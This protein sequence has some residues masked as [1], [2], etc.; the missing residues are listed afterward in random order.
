MS[1]V[2]LDCPFSAQENRKAVVMIYHFIHPFIQSIAFN[3]HSHLSLPLSIYE[4]T[5]VL[6]YR[7]FVLSRLRPKDLNM[8]T[9]DRSRPSPSSSSS[10]CSPSDSALPRSDRLSLK[11]SRMASSRGSPVTAAPVSPDTRNGENNRKSS[12]AFILTGNQECDQ[13]D[14]EQD[15]DEEETQSQEYG[16]YQ[17]EY[18]ASHS[19]YESHGYS[20]QYSRAQEHAQ[21]Y[22]HHQHQKY[23]PQRSQFRYYL[24]RPPAPAAVF[25]ATPQMVLQPSSHLEVRSEPP[26]PHFENGR[27]AET[28]PRKKV[29]V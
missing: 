17:Q 25:S 14:D 20:S 3:P 27:W 24:P 21:H 2:N 10:P 15:D 1:K 23:Q 4:A 28:Q 12:L 22:S 5:A 13:E 7:S 16:S 26:Q 18:V 6:P 19:S 9:K 29:R 8:G 11:K